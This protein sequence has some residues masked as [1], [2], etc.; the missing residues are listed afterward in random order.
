MAKNN[1]FKTEEIDFIRENFAAMTL[2]G[3]A[4]ALGRSVGGVKTWTRKLGLRRHNRF[5]WTG[6]RVQELREMFGNK[7]TAEIADYFGLSPHSISVKAANLGLKKDA[8]YLDTL[9][10]SLGAQLT[11]NGSQKRFQKG[12]KPWCA[13]KKIGTRGRS[14]ETQFKKGQMPQNHLKIGEIRKPGGYWKIKIVE[15]NIWEFL[16]IHIWKKAH[17]EV[18][19][20]MCIV[21]KDKNIDNCVI[22]NLDCL[23]RGELLKGHSIHTL[24]DELKQLYWT[25]GRLNRVINKKEKEYA[26][27][28][29]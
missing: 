11:I 22:E 20:D 7:P 15:P 29:N 23:T 3:L 17:G 21:F 25:L 26:E 12:Q 16:H 18:P 2:Q 6:E 8:R 1:P 5:V 27:K 19:K 13:G 28:Q 9:Q 24:P 14:A 10:K 4:D